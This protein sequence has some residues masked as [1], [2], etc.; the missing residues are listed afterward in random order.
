MSATVLKI[1]CCGKCKAERREE[2]TVYPACGVLSSAYPA[3]VAWV[4][5]QKCHGRIF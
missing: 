1:S 2:F 4:I 5:L 3:Y